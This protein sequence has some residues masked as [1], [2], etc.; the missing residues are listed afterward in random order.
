MKTLTRLSKPYGSLAAAAILIA[1]C[2]WLAPKSF[3]ATGALAGPPPDQKTV[4]VLMPAY[5][6][7]GIDSKKR[8]PGDQVEATTAAQIEL[9]DGTL[10][11]R[12]AKVVGHV[13]DSKARS[14]GDSQS[15]LTI[16]FE[17]VMLPQG[18]VL[19]VKG[20]LQAVGPNPNA[21]QS[22]GGVDYGSSLSRSLQHAGP[23][24]TA[25]SGGVP[26]LDAESVG[27]HGIKDLAL[28]EQ[29]VLI[30]SG[31]SVKLDHG[32]QLLLK[33]QVVSH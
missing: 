26:I 15:S 5:L 21:D 24:Q 3:A 30:S 18:K 12:A 31:K 6:D 7:I 25:A 32:S 4:S 22:G 9:P 11:P 33:M 17:K 29:G 23:G 19:D 28:D 13:T 16:V 27:A 1:A 2:F 8:N 14:K 10:I 20:S